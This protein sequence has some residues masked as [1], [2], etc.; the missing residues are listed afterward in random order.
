MTLRCDRN[1]KVQTNIIKI[2]C[3]RIVKKDNSSWNLVAEQRDLQDF[4]A[5]E[6]NL[7]A[8]AKI[9]GDTSNAFLQVSWEDVSDNNFGV[10]QCDVT[11]YDYKLNIIIERTSEIDI[12]E[13]EVPNKY[14][15]NLFQNAQEAVLDLQKFFDTEIFN[16]ESRLKALKLAIAA[17]EDRQ[18]SFQKSLMALELNQS[19]IENRLTAV[20][21]LR[22]GHMHWPG[23]FYALPKPNTGCPQNGAFLNGT[24]QF[25][26]I[27][28]ES[29]WSNDPSDSHSCAFPAETLSYVNH[30][31]FVTLEFCEII[32][33]PRA[34]HW[35]HGS[36]CIN[37][38]VL[39]SCPEGFTDGFVQFHNEDSGGRHTEGKNQVA[40]DDGTHV[41][42]FFCCQSSGSA[43]TPIELPSGSPFMLYR[44]SGACQQVHGMTVSDEYLLFNTEDDFADDNELSGTHPDVDQP[45]SVLHFHMCYYTRK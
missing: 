22:V 7:T 39:Q 12:Q 21:T 19:L 10:F 3:M 26:K 41:K 4:P 5:V 35:P 25:Q 15:V 1:S 14:L 34:P 23:G 8:L 20:E 28:T 2:F 40:A 36:F 9:E 13:S 30:R 45:G 37:K 17:F 16:V 42:L 18:T 44:N 24:E 27:H 38:F 11:G 31:K 6:E 33:Q 32:Y 43:M 29:R